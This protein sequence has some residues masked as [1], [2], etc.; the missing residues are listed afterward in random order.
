MINLVLYVSEDCQ[1]IEKGHTER[2]VVILLLAMRLLLVLLTALLTALLTVNVMIV[3]M[4]M[5]V[6]VLHN[7][8]II[9]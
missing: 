5:P 9:L 3:M 2:Y 1:E 8:Y 7:Y 6:S 4:M